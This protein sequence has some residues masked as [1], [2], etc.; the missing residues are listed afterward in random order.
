MLQR[1]VLRLI[2]FA[3]Q[4][5]LLR[6]AS[7]LARRLLRDPAIR[8]RGHRVQLCAGDESS[9]HI[10]VSFRFWGRWAHERY[11]QEV[12]E[13]LLGARAGR[14]YVLDGGAS[15]GL[16]SLLAASLSTVEKVVAVEA[17]PRVIA[18]LRRTVADA[19]LGARIEC[20]HAGLVDRAD[21]ML[22]SSATREHSEWTTV[23]SAS[24]GPAA[25]Q[26]LT[27]VTGDALVDALGLADDD[28]LF[29]KLDIEGS[30][31]AA[32]AGLARTLAHPRDALYMIEFHTG[33]LNQ[34]PGGAT[35]F[36]DTLWDADMAAIYVI[37]EDGACLRPIADR[38]AFHALAAALSAARFPYNLA[39]LLLVKR[40]LGAT[41]VTVQA[42]NW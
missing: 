11:A 34:Q 30:E 12:V 38:A 21:R 32:L 15:F 29:V 6:A 35:A 19:D 9:A 40:G 10:F 41:E 36:A 37:D 3:W 25:G 31:A 4:A 22:V 13:R 33:I 18:C 24:R 27:A 7:G 2:P 1:T 26:A 42:A 14:V 8:H 5:A 39:N 28:T 17:D 16:Y 20:V 23:L